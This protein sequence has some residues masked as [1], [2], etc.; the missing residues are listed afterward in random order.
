MNSNYEHVDCFCQA[1]TKKN[2]ENLVTPNPSVKARFR[3][4][5]NV[6]INTKA[7]FFF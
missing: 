7:L 3:N 5:I 6:R 4:D 2:P 1:A